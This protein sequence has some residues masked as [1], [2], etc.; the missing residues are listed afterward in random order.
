MTAI[1]VR[2]PVKFSDREMAWLKFYLW[3][4]RTGRLT[5]F[6]TMVGKN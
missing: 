2:E 1:P 6:P 5:E 4:V 3:M